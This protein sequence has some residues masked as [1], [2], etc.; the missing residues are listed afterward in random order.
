L[1]LSGAGI[2]WSVPGIS[3]IASDII[4]RI[5]SRISGSSIIIDIELI[6]LVIDELDPDAASGSS[7]PAHAGT[8]T[9]TAPVRT[10]PDRAP[11]DTCT[12]ERIVMGIFLLVRIE[13]RDS[14]SSTA[15]HHDLVEP[16]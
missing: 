2:G 9:R 13:S 12:T 1:A 16:M 7:V 8:P 4:E 14:F 15:E 6:M 5:C 10:A 11:A 3:S